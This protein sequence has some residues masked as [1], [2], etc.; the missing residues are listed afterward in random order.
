[1]NGLEHNAPPRAS[2]GRVMPTPGARLHPARRGTRLID[3]L[4]SRLG[5]A[6]RST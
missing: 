5:N 6:A 3:V 1:M 2:I 4:S